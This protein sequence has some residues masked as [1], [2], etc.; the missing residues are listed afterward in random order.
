MSIFKSNFES[1]KLLW[2]VKKGR[3]VFRK[4]VPLKQFI[5]ISRAL[6]FDYF[7]I[8]KVRR[9]FDKLCPIREVFESWKNCISKLVILEENLTTHEQLVTF[10]GNY[11]YKQCVPLRPVVYGI[12]LFILTIPETKH[13]HNVSIYLEKMNK[14]MLFL[15]I[16]LNL[17]PL[18]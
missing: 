13:T 14:K 6:Y 10:R 17:C 5:E 9:M 4:I 16:Y 12:S 2:S 11:P 3:S 8:R 18:Q 15:I 1:I 7:E